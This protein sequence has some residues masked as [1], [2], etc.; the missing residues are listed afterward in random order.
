MKKERAQRKYSKKF[1]NR[2]R[3]YIKS[4]KH[5]LPSV[6][7]GILLIGMLVS[8]I[9][10]LRPN[11]SEK[12]KRKLAEFPDFS[13]SALLNGSYFRKID[14]WFSDTFP[15]RDG[16]ISLNSKLGELRGFGDRIYGLNNNVAQTIPQASA[17]AEASKTDNMQPTDEEAEPSVPDQEG[18]DTQVLSNIIV[19][20]NAGY[21]YCSF[22]KISSDKYV[23]VIN[24]TAKALKGQSR[25]YSMLVPLSIDI[26]ISDNVRKGIN[27]CDQSAAM[28]YIYGSLSS[29]ANYV[30]I[31]KTM[32]MHRDEYIYYRTDHHWTALGA[33]Y[34]YCDLAKAAGFTP[35]TLDK[36]TK[37]SY[38]DFLG[39]FFSDTNNSEMKKTPDELIAYVPKYKT[40][41]T[42]TD[43]SG[44]TYNWKLVN[45]V[46][47]Y[48]VSL[49]YSAFSAG[50]NPYTVIENLSKEKGKSCLV[51]KE[52][53]GNA[54]IP[55]IAGHYKK[56]YVVDYRYY[57]SGFLTLAKNKKI[58]DIIFINNMSA[59]RNEKLIDKLNAVAR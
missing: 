57:K 20:G 27:S 54:V 55:Y 33:Y 21:E 28:D 26:M 49:K 48:G 37:E 32:R 36:F 23:S 2:V 10:P 40:K 24:K 44:K 51:I 7:F 15:M 43:S 45:D 38:G 30:N 56:V 19:I 59:V 18:E 1:I 4:Y 3:M 12:E 8:M 31:F 41:M 50:D 9:I 47:N 39:S 34:A 13:F 6:F 22:N 14:T 52:S 17:P 35:L 46:S 11:F 5:I 42:V 16:M 25:I 53:F 29:D 58:K